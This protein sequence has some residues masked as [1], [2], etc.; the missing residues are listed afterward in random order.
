MADNNIVAFP[1]LEPHVRPDVAI[2]FD[3]LRGA[4]EVKLL[5]TAAES[6]NF[7]ANNSFTDRDSELNAQV[8]MDALATAF[9]ALGRIINVRMC[10]E[11]A[12][13]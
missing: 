11:D 5:A 4:D 8:R 6:I 2:I 12:A 7:V 1:T 9:F 10:M 3:L 13:R